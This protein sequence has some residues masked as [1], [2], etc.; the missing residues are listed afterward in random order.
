VCESRIVIRSTAVWRVR[1][2]QHSHHAGGYQARS[3]SA[4]LCSDKKV[5]V[6]RTSAQSAFSL[7]VHGGGGGSGR[8]I[9]RWSAPKEEVAFVTEKAK[10]D[11]FLLSPNLR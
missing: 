2:G 3:Q 4:V 9:V 6:R 8:V 1:I 10:K 11:D 7:F 5:L